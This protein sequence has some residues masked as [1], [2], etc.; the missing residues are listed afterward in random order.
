MIVSGEP[1]FRESLLPSTI[2]VKKDA[3][4]FN[5]EAGSAQ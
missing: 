1:W 3:E 2:K 5:I 4:T